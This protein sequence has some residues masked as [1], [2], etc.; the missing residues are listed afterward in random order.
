MHC[1]GFTRIVRVLASVLTLWFGA[2][3]FAV[4]EQ[5]V[6]NFV[7]FPNGS[8][9]E[10]A[11][12]SDAAGNLYTTTQYGGAHGFGAVIELTP[13]SSGWTEH[14]LYSFADASDGA[15][16]EGGLA[17]DA[18]GNLYG[19]T[20]LGGPGATYGTVYKLSPGASSWTLTTIHTFGKFVD[21]RNPT[22]S[23]IFDASGNLYGTTGQGGT[24]DSG[25]VFEVSPSPTGWTESVLYSFDYQAGDG[26][27]PMAGV[28]IDAKG[29]LYG[30]T[31]TGPRDFSGTVFE[32]SP[33]ASGWV[34]TILLGFNGYDGSG[35]RSGLIL[36]KAGNLYGTAFQGGSQGGGVVYELVAASSW[37][38]TILY[39]FTAGSTD[40]SGLAGG[41]TF[42]QAGNLYG[43]TYY[44]GT[45]A[46]GGTL[47]CGTVYELSTSLSGWTKTTLHNFMGG[48]DGSN[49]VTS[50][51]VDSAGNVYGTTSELD[52]IDP[53]GIFTGGTVYKLTPGSGGT[54]T[55]SVLNFTATDGYTPDSDM[56]FD[57]AGNLYG[58]S[59]YGGAYGQGAV[60]EL[61]P[62]KGGTWTS[63]LLYSFAS[64]P[65][66]ANPYGQLVFD[67]AGNLY[68]TTYVGGTSANCGPVSAGCG[69]VYRLSPSSNGTWTEQVL[70][71]FQGPLTDAFWPQAGLAID[72]D[73]NLFGTTTGGGTNNT[74]TAFELSPNGSG[75]TESLIHSFIGNGDGLYPRAGMIWD[76]A[77]NLYGTTYEG[78]DA[79][80]GAGTVFKLSPGSDGAWTESVLYSFGSTQIGGSG[81]IAG[82]VFDKLGN[83][84]G[85]TLWGGAGAGYGFGV[86]YRLTLN[87]SGKWFQ[88]VLH[89]FGVSTGDGEHPECDL[90][91]D[92]F[93]NLYG[94]TSGGG[95]GEFEGTVFELSPGS[96]GW[97]EN[98]LH[99]FTGSDGAEPEAGLAIDSAGKLYGTAITGGAGNAGVVFEVTP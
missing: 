4:T 74:G 3:A 33:T 63:K 59:V 27:I 47:G 72:G 8:T 37:S 68:G 66:G 26:I 65:D 91:F 57:S 24:H 90:V 88:T 99:S 30:T 73:G 31:S 46:C 71:S 38:Q 9:P 19:T 82:V 14:V 56:I 40:G 96:S 89:S 41:L 83:L 12:V 17:F 53:P 60:F 22:G 50:P 58:T 87:S 11:F 85:T 93:G 5:T 32:L 80:N 70:Y 1:P 75:W 13:T 95:L 64:T 97:T 18:A 34:E 79:D 39:D 29:N 76:S 61:S 49:P 51:F 77:G 55:E 54:W 48:L 23:V 42:D 28:V 35:T 20:N 84:Y 44:G 62:A 94:T 10:A 81:P 52:P 86:V 43:T 92:E 36:D 25:A 15:E 2:S 98:I 78:G 69:T 67:G 16:P 21:G 45:G 6:H 7:T